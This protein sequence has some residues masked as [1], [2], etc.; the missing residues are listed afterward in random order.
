MTE[1]VEQEFKL[2][3][4][5][6]AA[7]QG[8]LERLGG[9]ASG[10][11]L[12]VNYFFDT[13]TR[14]LRHAG[15][16]LRLRRETAGKQSPP[17]CTLALKGPLRGSDPA[18]A[19]RPEEELAIGEVEANAL[20]EGARSPLEILDGSALAATALVRRAVELVGGESLACIGSFENER[21]RVGPLAA[22]PALAGLVLELDRTSFPGGRVEREL[23]VELAPGADPARIERGLQALFREL[24]IP[25]ENVP[26]KAAR[27]FRLLDEDG[28]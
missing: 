26:S 19:I 13:R 6:V 27:L 16:A 20:L 14:S 28:A 1:R 22:P 17:V 24:G 2:R 23:E 5:S 9:A 3:L 21:T 15:L 25:V 4:P 7:W 18:L 12:Q 8:L 11:V 10:P